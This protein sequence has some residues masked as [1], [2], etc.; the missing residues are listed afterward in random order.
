[1]DQSLLER[2]VSE[3]AE[4]IEVPVDGPARILAQKP[5]RSRGPRPEKPWAAIV[6]ITIVVGLVVLIAA[7]ASGGGA[8]KSGSAA[9]RADTSAATASAAAPATGPAGGPASHGAVQGATFSGVN[10]TASATG[11]GASASAAAGTSPNQVVNVAARVIKTGSVDLTLVA[12]SGGVGGAMDRISARADGYGGYVSASSV[13]GAPGAASA[14]GSLTVRVP[15]AAFDQIVAYVRSLG[16]ATSVTTSGQDVTSTYVD[17]QARITALQDARAQFEQI[18]ARAS[19]IGDI[20]SVESQINDLETQVEQLQ[21]Q[22]QLLDN[23]TSYST[24]TVALAWQAAP[25]VVSRPRPAGG[26]AKAWRQARDDFV[27]GF[28]A[29]V[30]SLGGIALFLVVAGAVLLLGRLIWRYAIRRLV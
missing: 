6:G 26:M 29:V 21:G 12:G 19:T 5:G 4:D 13:Q 14:T 17:L 11:S 22:L 2:L 7:I 20:L 8:S 15:A 27:H 28:E 1:M 10:G 25:G 9:G 24:L 30:G 16:S 3:A 18:L 23:Q